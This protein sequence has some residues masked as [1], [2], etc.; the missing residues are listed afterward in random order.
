MN[1]SFQKQFFALAYAVLVCFVVWIAKSILIPLIFGLIFAFVIFPVVKWLKSKGTGLVWAIIFTISAIAVVLGGTL[2]LFSAKLVSLIEEFKNFSS[3]LAD[4]IETSIQYVNEQLP[5]VDN[6]SGEML[7][8]NIGDFFAN[9]GF[10]IVS[11]TLSFTGSFFS[12]FFLTFLYTF[13]ILLYYRELT[14]ATVQFVPTEKREKFLHMLKSVQA[15][16]QQ[17]LLGMLVLILILG[18][19]NSLGL[20]LIGLDNALFFGFL[21]AVLAIIPYIGTIL[22][23][24]IPTLYALIVFDSIWYP[25]SVVLMFWF[26][27]ALEGNILSPKIVGGKLNLNALSALIALIAGGSLWGLPGMILALP[28]A[29]I[30][31]VIFDH[32]EELKPVAQLLEDTRQQRESGW[33]K[34]IKQKIMR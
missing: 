5:F 9:S 4:L 7:I 20:F 6:L 3:K 19:L 1:I 32:Y 12:Y 8:N 31:K 22:G 17:Y 15:V 27:Q 29:A 16:G 23:G 28:I 21:A 30:L 34:K 25:I 11:D 24:I 14:R 33:L 18:S 13:L 26:V 2:V 10:L